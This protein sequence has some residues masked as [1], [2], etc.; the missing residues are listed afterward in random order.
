MID[1]SVHHQNE[2]G[3]K[4]EVI[5]SAPGVISLLGEHNDFNEGV[6][7]QFALNKRVQ[8]AVSRRKDSSLRFFAADFGERKRTT[9]ANLKY[10]REDRWANYP[11]GVLAEI[12]EEGYK[13][14]GL[15][16][17]IYGEV[18]LEIGLA[19][20]SALCTAATYALRELYKFPFGDKECVEI[21]MRA[22]TAFIGRETSIST[23]ITSALGRAGELLHVDVRSL[24]YEFIP[25]QSDNVLLLLTI[26]NVPKVLS[27][28]ELQFRKNECAKCVTYLNEHIPGTALRDYTVDDLKHGIGIVPESTR[29]L[30][31]HVVEENLR[32]QEG[33]E[34]LQNG[35]LQGLGKILNK[36]HESLRDYYEISCHE[37]DWLVKRAWEME[38]VIGSR[39]I[40]S[41]FGGCTITLLQKQGLESYYRRLEEYERIFGF[42]AETV[43]CEP[44]AGVEA[45]LPVGD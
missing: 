32:V 35:D 45:I 12:A 30:C 16:F 8:V 37:I 18:P 23:H 17:T 9:V 36:S 28:P 31:M 43:I 14:K 26:S 33:K 41:G 13:F 44:S 1:I 27:D 38:E 20:S 5:F 15:N 29:R 6:M 42:S 11:K 7:L 25:F 39:L 40:G 3:E 21:S 19:S 24:G 2:Y 22:E 10:K 4:P 34:A